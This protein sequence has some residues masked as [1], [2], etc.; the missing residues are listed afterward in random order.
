MGVKVVWF[1]CVLH[2]SVLQ[3]GLFAWLQMHRRLDSLDYYNLH[4]CCR[5]IYYIKQETARALCLLH[6]TLQRCYELS[7]A[8][9]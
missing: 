6:V 8:Y 5:A 4:V 1:K 7:L 3:T 9:S 2:A